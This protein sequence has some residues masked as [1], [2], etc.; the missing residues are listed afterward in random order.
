MKHPQIPRNNDMLQSFD[1]DHQRYNMLHYVREHL[2][3]NFCQ[4]S[5]FSFVQDTIFFIWITQYVMG[6]WNITIISS[7]PSYTKISCDSIF[8]CKDGNT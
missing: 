7:F 1:N 6:E 8:M 4:T 5:H 3:A 2:F